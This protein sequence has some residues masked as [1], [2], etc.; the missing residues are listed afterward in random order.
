MIERLLRIK[1]YPLK[2]LILVAGL[3]QYDP[4]LRITST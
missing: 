3:I 4:S 2:L 1:Y